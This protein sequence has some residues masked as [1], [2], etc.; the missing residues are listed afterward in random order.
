MHN[1]CIAQNS[2]RQPHQNCKAYSNSTREKLP[3]IA[4][5]L[6]MQL[7]KNYCDCYSYFHKKEFVIFRVLSLNIICIKTTTKLMISS[8]NSNL[9]IFLL[10][11]E[12]IMR[13]AKLKL[14]KSFLQF[15][16][17]GMRFFFF[18]SLECQTLKN[19]LASKGIL[20]GIHYF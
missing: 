16:F 18:H 11:K 10:S 9:F 17:I 12:Q 5:L 20:G 3:Y 7:I 2:R 13:K 8:T 15:S 14:A 1:T 19:A 6:S 4:S